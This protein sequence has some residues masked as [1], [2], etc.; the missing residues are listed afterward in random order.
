MTSLAHP[1]EAFP[2]APA[3]GRIPRSSE[4]PSS[5]AT[6]PWILRFARTPDATQ[7]TTI[8]PTIYDPALQISVGLY[9]G[10]LPFMET[11]NPTVPDGNVTNPPP[12]DEGAK[13]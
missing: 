10:P 6:R 12:L 9:E 1:R 11:H 4:P 7:A 2:L 5:T 3:D 8:P 13:D